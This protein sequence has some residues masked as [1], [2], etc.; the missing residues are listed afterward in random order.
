[1]TSGDLMT[2]AQV[3]QVTGSASAGSLVLKNGEAMVPIRI[4]ASTTVTR[5]VD[6]ATTVNAGQA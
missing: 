6:A 5:L 2:N 3:D 4:G 1:M